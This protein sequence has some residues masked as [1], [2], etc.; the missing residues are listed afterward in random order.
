M[1]VSSHSSF[2]DDHLGGHPTHLEQVHFLPVKLEYAGCGVRQTDERQFMLPPVFPKSLSIFRSH[3][4]HFC[5]P[6]YEFIVV[7]AQL[8]HVLLAERSGEPAVEHQ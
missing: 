1:H 5:F 7:L 8:R 3:H 6:L 4:D 2:V